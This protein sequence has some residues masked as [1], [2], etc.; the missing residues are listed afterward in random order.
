MSHWADEY[1]SMIEDC[2]DRSD[3]LSDWEADFVSSLRD[4]LE[5]NGSLS[6][7]QVEKLEQ[8]WEKVTKHG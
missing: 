5:T 4:Q 6:P 2:E 1:M 3:N 8:V 7:R